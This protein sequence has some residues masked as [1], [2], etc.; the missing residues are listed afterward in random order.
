MLPLKETKARIRVDASGY[1]LYIYTSSISNVDIESTFWCDFLIVSRATVTK[2][3]KTKKIQ[4][5]IND[6]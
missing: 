1:I 4:R 3:R 5:K 2:R 6:I